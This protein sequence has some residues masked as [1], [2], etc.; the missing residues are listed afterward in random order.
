MKPV[1]LITRTRPDADQLA[2]RLED[3]GYGTLIEPMLAVRPT[4]APSP[5]DPIC[6]EGLVITSAQAM[7]HLHSGVV[8]SILRDKPVYAVG[9]KTAAIARDRGFTHVRD[10]GG[11][12]RALGSFLKSCPEVTPS[13]RLMHVCGRD[14]A[15]ETSDIMRQVPG[16]VW[17]WVV[18]EADPVD[19]FSPAAMDAMRTKRV[20]AVLLYSARAGEALTTCVQAYEQPEALKNTIILCLSQAV[21]ESVKSIPSGG[22]YAAHTPDEDALLA[23]LRTHVPA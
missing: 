5:H 16:H 19:R 11:D 15:H 13:S 2:L 17:T 22:T 7:R 20:R 8:R 4:H 14:I 18:Y 1:V 23:L 6:T 12:V 3:M 9:P 10:G 21:L